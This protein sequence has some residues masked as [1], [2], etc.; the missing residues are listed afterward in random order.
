MAPTDVII[1]NRRIFERVTTYFSTHIKS[2]KLLKIIYQYVTLLVF[3]AYPL[4]LVYVF[5]VEFGVD[6]GGVVVA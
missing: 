5:F 2:K 4:L 6:L 3:F 1:I